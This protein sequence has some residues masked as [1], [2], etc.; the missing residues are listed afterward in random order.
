MFNISLRLGTGL[1]TFA[2]GVIALVFILTHLSEIWSSLEAL[3]ALV[4][5]GID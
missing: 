3:L 5:G 4:D 2:I 1:V